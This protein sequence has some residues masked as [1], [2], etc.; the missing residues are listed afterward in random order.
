MEGSVLSLSKRCQFSSKPGQASRS[1]DK[2]Q[3]SHQEI[4]DLSSFICLVVTPARSE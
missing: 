3:T 2:N 1:S 4:A